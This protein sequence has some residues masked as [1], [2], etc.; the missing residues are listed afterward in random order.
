MK[1]GK[2]LKYCDEAMAIKVY[3]HGD[4]L[5]KPSYKGTVAKVPFYL[6]NAKIE[7]SS[8]SESMGFGAVDNELEGDRPIL[9][10]EVKAY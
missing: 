4:D 6:A 9:A 2:L 10:V 7:R 8:Y 1:L 3:E 5:D